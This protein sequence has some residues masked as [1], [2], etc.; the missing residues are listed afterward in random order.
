MAGIEDIRNLSAPIQKNPSQLKADES[1]II[2]IN[3]PIIPPVSQYLLF[4]LSMLF[5]PKKIINP[6]PIKPNIPIKRGRGLNPMK[7]I[8]NKIIKTI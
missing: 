5:I 3:N 2:Q 8:I 6:I 7:A 1:N 4:L